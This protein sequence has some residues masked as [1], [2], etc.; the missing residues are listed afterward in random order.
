MAEVPFGLSA[1]G[2]QLSQKLVANGITPTV[3]SK[4]AIDVMAQAAEYVI[5]KV[6]DKQYNEELLRVG[7]LERLEGD[8]IVDDFVIEY[9]SQDLAMAANID[10][11][12][13]FSSLIPPSYSTNLLS[14]E[15]FTRDWQ[16]ILKNPFRTTVEALSSAR[17]G[18]GLDLGISPQRAFEKA[19][20]GY[21][22]ENNIDAVTLSKP[23]TAIEFLK[24]ELKKVIGTEK[25]NDLRI[26]TLHPSMVMAASIKAAITQLAPEL[27]RRNDFVVNEFVHDT[28]GKQAVQLDT[29]KD[30]YSIWADIKS[31]DKVQRIKDNA[32]KISSQPEGL[33][34]SFMNTMRRIN[35]MVRGTSKSLIERYSTFIR[36]Q[37]STDPYYSIIVPDGSGGLR[38]IDFHNYLLGSDIAPQ[39]TS[40]YFMP[41]SVSSQFADAADIERLKSFEMERKI[42]QRIA[43]FENQF[44]KLNREQR[45]QASKSMKLIGKL[46]PETL[47][48]IKGFI[49]DGVPHVIINGGAEPTGNIEN[50]L[51]HEITLRADHLEDESGGIEAAAKLMVTA[52][53][54]KSSYNAA[55]SKLSE[56]PHIQKAAKAFLGKLMFQLEQESMLQS[57]SA[58]LGALVQKLSNKGLLNVAGEIER[59]K[60]Y[61]DKI[62]SMSSLQPD[63]ES[64]HWALAYFPQTHQSA[65]AQLSAVRKAARNKLLHRQA[66]EGNPN[67]LDFDASLVERMLEETSGDIISKE[68][69]KET[70]AMKRINDFL[71]PDSSML[72]KATIASNALP[73]TIEEQIMLD[74]QQTLTPTNADVLKEYSNGW[75]KSYISAV[76]VALEHLYRAELQEQKGKF[77]QQ[78]INEDAENAFATEETLSTIT[79]LRGDQYIW[80]KVIGMDSIDSLVK[81]S[82]IQVSYHDA[83]GQAGYASGYFIGTTAGNMIVFDR[84]SY[85][86]QFLPMTDWQAVPT[87]GQKDVP[88]AKGIRQV[89]LGRAIPSP[90]GVRP[91]GGIALQSSIEAAIQSQTVQDMVKDALDTLNGVQASNAGEA[92]KRYTDLEKG[93]G[94]FIDSSTSTRALQNAAAKSLVGGT[95]LSG[96][97]GLSKLSHAAILGAAS[98][99]LVAMNEPTASLALAGLSGKYLWDYAANIATKMAN[100]IISSRREHIN[101]M[102]LKAFSGLMDVK[103]YTGKDMQKELQSLPTFVQEEIGKQKEYSKLKR[104]ENKAELEIMNFVQAL[105]TNKTDAAEKFM[106]I[107]RAHALG[108][109]DTAQVMKMAQEVFP[110]LEQKSKIKNKALGARLQQAM[111]EYG[112]EPQL[113]QWFDETGVTLDELI[114]LRKTYQI[115][116]LKKWSGINLIPLSETY[117]KRLA[118]TGSAEMLRNLGISA[119]MNDEAF[120]RSVNRISQ[121]SAGE[122]GNRNVLERTQLGRF[123]SLYSRFRRTAN[124]YYLNDV[125]KNVS[126]DSFVHDIA[127]EYFPQQQTMQ[128]KKE[129][130]S[131]EDR[132]G[133][134]S[135]VQYFSD[136][137]D[138]QISHVEAREQYPYLRAYENKLRFSALLGASKAIFGY[139]LAFLL[140]GAWDDEEGHFIGNALVSAQKGAKVIEKAFDET[141]NVTGLDSVFSGV[142]GVM[143]NALIEIIGN[144]LHEDAIETKLENNE[145]TKKEAQSYISN[146]FAAPDEI[147]LTLGM[148]K[149]AGST[150][151]LLANAIYG[152]AL[153]AMMAT[154]AIGDGYTDSAEQYEATSKAISRREAMMVNQA[155]GALYGVDVLFNTV[156]KPAIEVAGAVHNANTKRTKKERTAEKK[157]L[158]VMSEHNPINL[159]YKEKQ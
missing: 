66:E 106:K 97:L 13:E 115:E 98:A 110:L 142:I 19:F 78:G 94:N 146:L 54:M 95:V 155:L 24:S 133:V 30:I 15:S 7:Q 45:L 72:A 29:I 53:R 125:M 147:I 57:Y 51:E 117:S 92:T 123:L 79:E 100:N 47:V 41:V 138:D 12:S 61:M 63:S 154:G 62:L 149:G 120:Q 8:S 87:R 67:P 40:S 88:Q 22:K 105:A 127:A 159:L 10:A 101:V 55:S 104:Q 38:T 73:R 111:V 119:N 3:N 132:M 1:A 118:D 74:E 58:Q 109:V 27:V 83:K 116:F 64:Y 158:D 60:R 102:G 35:P 5:C 89:V 86:L 150:T 43:S 137:H 14:K 34:K 31:A 151:S 28:M 76:S 75:S 33:K 130:G 80:D 143:S 131:L 85:S 4:P 90:M 6:M 20:S 39:T 136:P 99:G 49:K 144:L 21:A 121:L 16:R 56:Q 93:I 26:D 2:L 135:D 25:Y 114:D 112:Y 68:L 77:V 59:K 46:I 18:I 48:G 44:D 145:W 37:L 139:G 50:P 84:N 122:Y 156:G 91:S 23:E 141:E 140:A 52:W 81:G 126:I 113:N 134:A 103:D 108:K 96:Y 9:A 17:L 157:A 69:L 11:L 42:D 107:K 148:G 124:S 70:G 82:P 153:A 71:Q 129:L 36:P 32:I 65:A 152:N 128:T